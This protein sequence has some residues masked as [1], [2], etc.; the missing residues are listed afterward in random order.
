MRGWLGLAAQGLASQIGGSLARNDGLMSQFEFSVTHR[1]AASSARRGIFLTPRGPVQTP[2]FMPVGTQGTVK[3]LTIDQ[4]AA[5]GAE[6]ILGNTYHLALRP[7]HETVRR[8]GGL[9]RACQVG[10]V[11]S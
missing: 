8:L 5:T 6:M 9:H 2:A 11:R 4:V 1:D 10:T 3:G 7:G